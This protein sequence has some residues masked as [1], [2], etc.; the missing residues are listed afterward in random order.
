MICN[1]IYIYLCYRL[2]HAGSLTNI[3]KRQIAVETLQIWAPL[4]FQLGMAGQVPELEVHSYVLLFPQSFQSFIGWYDR[5]R[6]LA[7]KVLRNFRNNLKLLLESDPRLPQLATNIKIQSRIKAPSSAFKKLV[8]SDKN[9][10]TDLHDILGLRVIVTEAVVP[11]MTTTTTSTTNTATTSATT[12]ETRNRAYKSTNSNNDEEDVLPSRVWVTIDDFYFQHSAN[13]KQQQ[14]QHNNNQ[15]IMT[16]N[17]SSNH[18][19]STTTSSSSVSATT[20]TTSASTS[21]ALVLHSTPHQSSAHSSTSSSSSSSS[22]TTVINEIITEE[23]VWRIHDLI[24]SIC[25]KDIH[26]NS[27]SN[28]GTGMKSE[29]D[30]NTPSS[31]TR[32][33]VN[34]QVTVINTNTNTVT[35]T[36]QTATKSPRSTK[37]WEW[38]VDKSRFKDYV[39]HPKS[40][41]CVFSFIYLTF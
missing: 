20:N 28:T 16:S 6:P 7:K 17:T 2:Q 24:N 18:I 1:N 22:K 23:A 34:K 5:F 12:K 40:S 30:K 29:N 26:S 8:R 25:K 38:V 37:G 14:Q 19:S 32:P 10:L 35:D 4:S 13:N 39:N 9:K 41:G 27:N 33:N 21:Y 11:I 3:L 31:A 36:R 15:T